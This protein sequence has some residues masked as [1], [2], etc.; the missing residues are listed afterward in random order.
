MCVQGSKYSATWDRSFWTIRSPTQ[1]NE[2]I[3]VYDMSEGS[4]EAEVVYF[5]PST[6][7]TEEDLS[8]MTSIEEALDMGAQ[9]GCKQHWNCH[10]R[11][12]LHRLG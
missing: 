8:F 2:A 10:Y 6:D 5:P 1:S 12:T 9:Y 7:I 11:C 4:K 3:Y